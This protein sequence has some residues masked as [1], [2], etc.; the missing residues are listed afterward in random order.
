MQPPA[1]KF[2]PRVQ[3]WANEWSLGCV[4]TRP[5]ARGSQEAGFTQP[6]GPLFCTTLLSVADYTRRRAA[7]GRPSCFVHC[8]GMWHSHSVSLSP[9][10]RP[11]HP[12]HSIP[13]RPPQQCHA[14]PLCALLR[15]RGFSVFSFPKLSEE[16]RLYEVMSPTALHGAAR[17]SSRQNESFHVNRTRRPET[18]PPRQTDQRPRRAR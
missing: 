13:H 12:T 17:P 8:G 10:Q 6:K 14:M 7:A 3:G 5:A 2:A 4:N 18:T 9:A 16:D 15:R 1:E 11:Y